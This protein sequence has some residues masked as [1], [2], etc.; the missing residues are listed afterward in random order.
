MKKVI[1]SQ[2]VIRPKNSPEP[3]NSPSGRTR[4]VEVTAENLSDAEIAVEAVLQ[5]ARIAAALE[6][7]NRTLSCIAK[8]L[9]IQ[10]AVTERTST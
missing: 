3:F 4:K 8:S 6:Q 9:P 5:L 10:S 1:I 7:L 2:T